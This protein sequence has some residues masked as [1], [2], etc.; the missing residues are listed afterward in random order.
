MGR[1]ITITEDNITEAL[2]AT[3]CK[4]WAD[5]HYVTGG[6]YIKPYDED[7]DN[8]FVSYDEMRDAF[9]ACAHNITS[10]GSGFVVDYIHGYFVSAIT[11]PYADSTP[12]GVDWGCIDTDAMDVWVQRAAF[13]K[14]VYG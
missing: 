6:L 14:L 10:D 5:V 1:T 12:G 9:V 13:G 11:N 8:V 4:Y 2:P 3:S 7:D